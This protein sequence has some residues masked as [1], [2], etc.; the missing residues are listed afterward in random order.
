[1][2]QPR[3]TRVIGITL[4]VLLAQPAPAGEITTDQITMRTVEALPACLNWMPVGLCFWLHCS[5]KGCTIK[6]S[7]KV[8]HYNPDLVVSAYNT[9]GDNPWRAI[10]D[11]LGDLQQQAAETLLDNDLATSIGSAGNR[12]EGTNQDHRNLIFREADAVGHPVATLSGLASTTGLLCPS[13]TE[14]FFPYFQSAFDAL[15]WR[16]DVPEGLYPASW[17]PGAREVGDWPRHTWGSVHPRTGWIT[18]TDEAKAA[19]VI[20]QRAGDIVTRSRQPHVYSALAK[21]AFWH[22]DITE[23]IDDWVGDDGDGFNRWTPSFSGVK[24]WP[25]GPLVE[26]DRKT[27]TW[28][29]L[30]PTPERSCQV[31]GTNDLAATN[32]WGGGKIAADGDYAWNLW[33][34]Y[35]CCRRAGQTFLYSIDFFSYPP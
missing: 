26:T 31:F 22:N 35:Q 6:T 14:P 28:Q 10:Q 4:C 23:I 2:T 8:G 5:W 18:Q 9:L 12:T 32:S 15:A 33:R 21:G 34:P 30:L 16:L 24:V 17:L 3:H 19:A 11:G 13:Q 27:G 25:P 29:M 1:M 20:A 7:V